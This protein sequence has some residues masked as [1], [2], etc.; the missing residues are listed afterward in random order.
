VT[1]SERIYFRDSVPFYDTRERV[2]D[3]YRVELEPGR[4]VR[5]VLLERNT[6]SPWVKGAWAAAGIL[7]AVSIGLASL[8]VFRKFLRLLQR[9]SAA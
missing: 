2:V 7:I 4:E 5:L 8:W 1:H 6:G 9:P 3:R